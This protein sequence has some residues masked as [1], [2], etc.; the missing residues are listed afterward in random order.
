M[1]ENMTHVKERL[2]SRLTFR[3]SF[4]SSSSFFATRIGLWAL[5]QALYPY[6][7]KTPAKGVS[8]SGKRTSLG[9]TS[10]YRDR[11]NIP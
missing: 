2:F 3:S 11:K 5:V 6:K 9:K 8:V 1:L 10:R 7:K 4:S